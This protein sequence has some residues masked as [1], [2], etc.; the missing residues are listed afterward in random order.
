MPLETPNVRKNEKFGAAPL[1]I[2]CIIFIGIFKKIIYATPCQFQI[3]LGIANKNLKD[4][5][6]TVNLSQFI[7]GTI[8]S[9]VLFV[10]EILY[11][12]F[13]YLFKGH[14]WRRLS[15]IWKWVPVISIS[16][17]N[18]PVQL[19]DNNHLVVAVIQVYFFLL[20]LNS[21]SNLQCKIN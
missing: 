1:C 20:I 2:E 7:I 4:S 17:I 14:F 15:K 9:C 3:F 6:W 18:R 5:V 11:L 8:D 13:I 21:N 19:L 10:I 16:T 12:S